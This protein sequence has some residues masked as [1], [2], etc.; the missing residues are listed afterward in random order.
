MVEK[1]VFDDTF[2]YRGVKFRV[3]SYTENHN[4]NTWST[5]EDSNRP[6]YRRRVTKL[7]PE[8][9]EDAL[10]NWPKGARS[11]FDI[12]TDLEEIKSEANSLLARLLPGR[13]A[14]EY[15]VH[16]VED[17]T[18]VKEDVQQII[19]DMLEEWNEHANPDGFH[20]YEINHP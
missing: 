12:H 16:E 5:M 20:E 9:D 18:S 4:P 17:P 10:E 15:V 14:N 11:R 19:K 6:S 3:E 2:E 8:N 13:L 7:Y 1:Y